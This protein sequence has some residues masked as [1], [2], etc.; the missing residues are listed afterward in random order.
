[1]PPTLTSTWAVKAK[2]GEPHALI[3]IRNLQSTARI[4]VDAWGRP[5]KSQPILV[6]VEVSLAQPFAESSSTDKVETDTVHYGRLSKA[7]L[8]TLREVD[9]A[10]AAGDGA[11]VSLRRLLDIIW[12]ELASVGVDGSPAPGA[13]DVEKAFLNLSGVRY[14]SVTL[15]LPKATLSGGGVSLT[16]TSL[17]EMGPLGPEVDVYGVC[18]QLHKLQVPTLIGINTNE[19]E[20]KQ[21]VIADIKIDKFIETTDVYPALEKAIHKAGHLHRP[22]SNP[23]RVVCL[24]VHRMY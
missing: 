2:A 14:L 18:L 3:R 15:H 10:A 16:G 8:A 4:G 19:R 13:V 9:T 24:C 7:V 1:M 22:P 21:L 5:N 6:S 17:F 23:A 12:W 11:A 20:A